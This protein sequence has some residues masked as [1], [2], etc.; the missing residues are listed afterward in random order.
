M[1]R[2]AKQAFISSWLPPLVVLAAAVGILELLT[3]GLH[4]INPFVMPSPSGI[5]R[6]TIKFFKLKIVTN[7]LREY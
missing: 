1:K 3:S 4:L 5:L 7:K 2:T 6:D